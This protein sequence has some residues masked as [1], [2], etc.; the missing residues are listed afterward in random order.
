[1]I[2]STSQKDVWLHWIAMDTSNFATFFMDQ[3]CITI[4]M[5]GPHVDPAQKVRYIWYAN[6]FHI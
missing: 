3:N 1:M 4:P 5:I 6:L 2:I